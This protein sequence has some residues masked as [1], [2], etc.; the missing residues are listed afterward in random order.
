MDESDRDH[1][2]YIMLSTLMLN[3]LIVAG[4]H[5]RYLGRE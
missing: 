2:P 5:N 4:V 3:I 1:I